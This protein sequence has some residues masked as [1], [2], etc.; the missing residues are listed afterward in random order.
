[1]DIINSVEFTLSVAALAVSLG[2]LLPIIRQA[3]LDRVSPWPYDLVFAGHLKDPIEPWRIELAFRFKNHT[4]NEAFFEVRL[5]VEGV[6]DPETPSHISVWPSQE[7]VGLYLPVAG[8]ASREVQI[9]PF[10]RQ[11]R[12]MLKHWTLIIIEYSHRNR[13][14]TWQWPE[15]LDHYTSGFTT[16]IPEPQS[17]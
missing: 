3:Y 16:D 15:D 4:R 7:K 8:G 13:P 12:R 11:D 2:T 1:M 10:G 9:S 5:G 6:S 14:A 17:R